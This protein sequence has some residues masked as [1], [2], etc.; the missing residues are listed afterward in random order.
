MRPF[1]GNFLRYYFHRGTFKWQISDTFLHNVFIFCY[2]WYKKIPSIFLN[3]NYAHKYRLSYRYGSSRWK[4]YE[5][6]CEISLSLSLPYLSPSPPPSFFLSSRN[7]FER[8]RAKRASRHLGEKKLHN[9][10]SSLT[11]W[12]RGVL[13]RLL[14]PLMRTLSLRNDT[15]QGDGG[16]PEISHSASSVVDASKVASSTIMPLSPTCKNTQKLVRRTQR[17]FSS[18]GRGKQ[19]KIFSLV[20]RFL[21][22]FVFRAEEETYTRRSALSRCIQSN[23]KRIM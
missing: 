12:F 8:A 17:A 3:I 15:S 23:N 18:N 2:I 13:E 4:K 5:L 9:H 7:L 20:S 1:G 6:G 21:L 16:P 10:E 22:L 14:R 11:L 19:T